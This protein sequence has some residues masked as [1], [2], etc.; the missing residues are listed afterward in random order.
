MRCESHG[1]L[2]LIDQWF[3]EPRAKTTLAK[4]NFLSQEWSKNSLLYT[5]YSHDG[6]PVLKNQTAAFYGGTIGYF[7]ATDLDNAKIIYDNKL[8]ILFNPDTNSWK[9]KL[10]YYDDNWV[11]F[12]LALYNNFLPN[13]AEQITNT[14]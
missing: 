3:D 1:V 13:L 7:M 8:Q 4:M 2:P 11:W 12:G 14:D 10:G 5:N 9:V 6:V